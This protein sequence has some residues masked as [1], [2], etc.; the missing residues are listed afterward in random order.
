[1]YLNQRNVKAMRGNLSEAELTRPCNK[2]PQPG[3]RPAA[4]IKQG[5]G[6]RTAFPQ[7]TELLVEQ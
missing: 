5:K 1:L 6:Y 4:G 7:V 3:T 2:T